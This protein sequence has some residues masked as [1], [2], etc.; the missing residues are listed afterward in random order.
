VEDGGALAAMVRTRLM[1]IVH[2]RARVKSELAAQGPLLEAGAAVIEA[3][4]D[5]LDDPQEL[6]PN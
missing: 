3:A 6:P 2:E 4:L 1:A 5:L